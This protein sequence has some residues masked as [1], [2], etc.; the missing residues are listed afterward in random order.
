MFAPDKNFKMWKSTKTSMALMKGTKEDRNHF[1]KMMIQA[2]LAYE[3]AKR[4][5]LKSKEGKK[6]FGPTR[7]AVAPDTE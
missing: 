1:K 4:A 6:D 5:A 3:A 2:Q 7:G